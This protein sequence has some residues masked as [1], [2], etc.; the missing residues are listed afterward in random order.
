METTPFINVNKSD[1]L[2]AYSYKQ[3]EEC[4]MTRGFVVPVKRF[5]GGSPIVLSLPVSILE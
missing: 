4:I 5:W 1:L 2:N 3:G